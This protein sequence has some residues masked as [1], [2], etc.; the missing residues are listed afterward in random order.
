ME[1]MDT[2]TLFEQFTVDEIRQVE[3][4]T[5]ADIEKKK[6]D[7]RLMVG[8]RYRELI[9]AA[10]TITDMKICSDRIVKSVKE[11]QNYCTTLRTTHLT[12]GIGTAIRTQAK[13][14]TCK[15][16][17]YSIA[18]QIKLLLDMPEK[19]WG[20]IENR[21]HLRGTQLYLLACHIMSS[22]QLDGV[23]QQSTQLL[24][25]FPILS[26]Q[27]AAVSHFKASI[28]Q[29]CRSMLKD[30]VM[31]DEDTSEA[32]CSIILLEDS[33]PRQV[34]TE[35]L[36]AR[37][38]AVQHCFQSAHHGASIKQ[39]VCN[40]IQLISTTIRQIYTIF[41]CDENKSGTSPIEKKQGD[42]PKSDLL[43]HTL[44]AVTSLPKND[45]EDLLAKEVMGGS[46]TKHLPASI[47]GFRPSL[48]TPGVAISAQ[49]LHQSVEEWV[50]TCVQ[51]VHTG[52]GRLFNYINTIKGL[53][54]IRDAL[55]ELLKQDEDVVD[56]KVAC[57]SI[58]NQPLSL[59]GEFVRPLFLNRAQAIIQDDLD[60][61]TTTIQNTTNQVIQEI[62]SNPDE[63]D[64]AGFVWTESAS[65]MPNAAAWSGG[66][67]KLPSD[68]G[69]LYMKTRAYTNQ[70]QSLC[71]AFNTKLQKLL[72]DLSIYTQQADKKENK[73]QLAGKSGLSMCGPFDRYS[74][75]ETLHSFLQLACTK[76]VHRIIDHVSSHLD[77]C[78]KHLA[79]KKQQPEECTIVVDRSVA[80]G[81]ICLA[82]TE[83]APNLQICVTIADQKDTKQRQTRAPTKSSWF[84]RSKPTQAVEITEWDQVK[85]LLQGKSQE[86][87]SIWGCYTAE[88]FLDDYNTAM[89][90]CTPATLLASCTQWAEV[91]IQEE[92]EDGKKISSK[93]RLPVQ[94]SWYVQSLLFE[95]CAEINRVG[96]HALS[97]ETICNLVKK[98][99]DSIVDIYQQLLDSKEVVIKLS[100][101]RV[102]QMLFDL[103]FVSTIMTGRG[104]DKKANTAYTA[105]VEKLIDRFESKIDP[106]DLDVFTS[107][108]NANLSRHIHR[109]SILLGAL[110]SLDKHVYS[111]HKAVQAGR[112]EH[113]NILPLSTS[114]ARFNLLPLSSQSTFTLPTNMPRVPQTPLSPSAFKSPPVKETEKFATKSGAFYS[115]L[116]SLKTSWLANI[117]KE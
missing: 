53:T 12:K 16:T 109:S 56:W 94:C 39:Q 55:W 98:V 28:L 37:K 70:V 48:R 96:G 73:Y 62:N 42:S 61:T 80:L 29:S 45:S 17:F 114:Q 79:E 50:D 95:L 15:S 10:D 60:K 106:F 100:Q 35:F 3:R 1:K 78:Q 90:K 116:G 43:L 101:P 49:Y 8:E 92:T 65:D 71:S 24:T 69:G 40:V 93:I 2:N 84:T 25:W 4:N 57:K 83:L 46:Y 77:T 107:H 102:L 54:S 47:T 6:E 105:K 103:R 66:S 74:D 64:I 63:R 117:G 38:T 51:D 7:L 11:M 113:H 14:K 110:T 44:T 91:E 30:S 27:W 89:L 22:L 82:L 87:F 104:D 26:R 41:Y 88:A 33:S 97:R 85:K 81:R 31:S 86:A 68:A 18:S 59:W 20:A 76:C 52:V 21:Q 34:F 108:F 32:L 112:Q 115:R 99:T 5:R 36:L 111:G 72:E 58:M 75:T 67:S 9:E 13:D 23:N 19:I